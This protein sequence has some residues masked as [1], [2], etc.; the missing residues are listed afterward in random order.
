MSEEMEKIYKRATHLAVVSVFFLIDILSKTLIPYI[1]DINCV[2]RHQNRSH[3]SCKCP[4]L[5]MAVTSTT[6]GT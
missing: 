4:K 1:R 5:K 6:V 3:E 2:Q